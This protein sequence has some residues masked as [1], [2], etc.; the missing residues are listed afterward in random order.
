MVEV[1]RRLVGIVID[2]DPEYVNVVS[3]RSCNSGFMQSIE[4]L[5]SWLHLCALYLEVEIR[6]FIV[7]SSCLLYST[8]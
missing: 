7:A 1:G 4:A 3:E 5:C 8:W 6:L 2:A